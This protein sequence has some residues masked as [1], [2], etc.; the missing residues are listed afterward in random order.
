MTTSVHH[1]QLYPWDIRHEL[2]AWADGL[3]G[4]DH[5]GEDGELI[6]FPPQAYDKEGRLLE[7]EIVYFPQAK[8]LAIQGHPEFMSEND[9][10]VK[11]CNHL[12]QERLLSNANT[13]AAA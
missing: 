8:C 10:F 7:P 9:P 2:I 1:Q 13:S 4:R 5:S 6:Q 3:V 12:I 11:Y